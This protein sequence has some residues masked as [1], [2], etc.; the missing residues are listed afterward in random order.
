MCGAVLT[1]WAN[2][3]ASPRISQ[4][5]GKPDTKNIATL[6]SRQS[7]RCSKDFWTGEVGFCQ[8]S[9]IVLRG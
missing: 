4:A 7:G 3:Q 5:F 8:L 9:D 6:T 1:L 2:P